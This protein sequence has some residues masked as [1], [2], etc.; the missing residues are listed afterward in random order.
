[1]RT[2][3]DAFAATSAHRSRVLVV[4]LA[5][6]VAA[7]VAVA[8]P[9]APAGA[10][11][12]GA[13]IPFTAATVSFPP[14]GPAV[15]SWKAPG[16]DEVTVYAGT[17]PKV[18]T[19]QEVGGGKGT[20]SVT[21][22][23]LGAAPRWYFRLQPDAG[24]PLVVADRSLHLASAPNFRDVGG[25]RTSDGKW[26]RM[27]VAYRAD[28]L[29]KITPEENATIQAL[30]I[31]V[32]CDFRTDAERAKAPDV[33]VAGATNVIDDVAGSDASGAAAATETAIR[34]ALDAGDAEFVKK[35]FGEVQADLVTADGAQAAYHSVLERLSDRATLPTVFH[36]TAGKD[37]TG[38]GTAVLLTALGVPREAVEA[39]YLLSNDAAVVKYGALATDPVYSYAVGVKPE[40]IDAS[41]AAVD[42]EFGSF[43]KYVRT[44]LD[45]DAATLARLRKNF[46]VG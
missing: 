29:D 40:Y 24:R 8:V 43:A 42:D 9:G 14:G 11:A 4:V 37:R 41:F 30:G 38:W 27:G 32:I 33:A 16:V 36:C 21:V 39:D 5:L 18:G 20:G 2:V 22:T 26:V 31:K 1:M 6:A 35:T 23:D 34:A 17:S 28:A 44:G 25:Y 19:D 3:P 45:I 7:S 12:D 13:A 15:V 10:A 46:L